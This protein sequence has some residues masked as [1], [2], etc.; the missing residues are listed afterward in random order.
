MNMEFRLFKGLSCLEDFLLA[1][2]ILHCEGAAFYDVVR[3]PRM[4]MPGEHLTGRYD[5]LPYG[6]CGRTAKQ[7]RV[8]NGPHSDYDRGRRI[9]DL[10]QKKGTKDDNGDNACFPG[11][12]IH[13]HLSCRHV[14]SNGSQIAKLPRIAAAK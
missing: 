2:S 10:A 1:A 9:R 5:Q 3:T 8:R 6:N 12:L 4:I 7:F 13:V 14:L 11:F